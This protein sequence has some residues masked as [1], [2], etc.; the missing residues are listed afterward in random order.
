MRNMPLTVVAGILM[1]AAPVAAQPAPAH[2]NLKAPD[3]TALKATYYAAGKPGPAVMLLHQCNADRTSWTSLAT[4]AAARGY[5]VLAL[6]YRGFGESGGTRADDPQVQGQVVAEKWPGDVDAAFTWLLAQPG[7]DKD[8]IGAAGASCGVNQS[9]QLARRHPEVKTVVLLSGGLTPEARL[10]L[11]TVPWM[12]V[13]AAASLDDGGTV[14]GMR[15]NIGWSRNPKN[16]FLEY[17]AAGHG[18]EMFAVEKGL[19]PAMLDWFDAHLRTAPVKPETTSA[20]YSPT[21]IETFW[22]TLIT[23][24]G[25]AAKAKALYEAAKREGKASGLWPEQ[26]MNLYGY[27]LIQEGANADALIVLQ[28]NADAYPQS[29][30]VYD[31]VADAFLANGNKEEALRYAE[32]AIKMLETDMRAPAAFKDAVRQSAEQKI[33]DLKKK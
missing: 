4:A 21:P 18:T 24:P 33:R 26:E 6:D 27:Q 9:V 3:G 16:K 15:W 29:A 8:R 19:Q 5:H 20:T 25:G 14:D 13:L 1:V 10:H 12:P 17:K 11:R 28:M 2:V 22:N 30:N 23:Q 32:K 31:S 7:V